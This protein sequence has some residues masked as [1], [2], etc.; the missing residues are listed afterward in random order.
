MRYIA[1]R[2]F[3][4][5]IFYIVIPI[6]GQFLIRSSLNFVDNFMVSGMGEEAVAGV[7]IANQ[8]YFLF[9][10]VVTSICTGASIFTAQY[11]GA[12][13]YDKLRKVFGVKLL[14]SSVVSLVFITIGYIFHEEIVL[15]FNKDN[16]KTINYANDYLLIMILSYLPFA[17]TQAYTFLLRPIGR[18]KIPFLV[19][20]FSML[21]NIILNYGLIYGN[22]GMPALGVSGAALG[23]V[24]ARYVELILFIIIYMRLDL[25]FKS[26]IK[27]YFKFTKEI[28]EN[29]YSKVGVLFIN[30]LLFT[31]SFV[32]IFK[33]FSTR[34]IIAISA[35][36][37]ANII[38][39]YVLILTNGTG[40]AT[41]ILVGNTLG[42]GKLDEAK[43]N[44][45]YLLGYSVM[46]GLVVMIITAIL[47]YFIPNMYH[48][49]ELETKELMRKLILVYGFTSPIVALTRIPFF[50]LRSGGRVLDV[51]ILDSTFMWVIKVPVAVTLAY[52][53]NLSIIW[54]VIG[55]E[56]TRVINAFISMYFYNKKQWLNSFE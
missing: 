51:L 20:G 25:P 14:F 45:D 36:N 55:V 28:L 7:A 3:Y 4:K 35:I 16:I 48:G 12:R 40:T 56:S 53:T 43:K 15:F 30:E 24:I 5:K 49:L 21:L 9:F 50:V 39:R 1:N 6:I 31:T 29:I 19:S 8:Y 44:A 2:Q 18:A 38:F 17:I 27:E 52:M 42:A 13:K 47:S 46:I 23:T 37:I 26:K 54:L 11:Y 10:P 32:F 33:T 41:A 34:G 22:L